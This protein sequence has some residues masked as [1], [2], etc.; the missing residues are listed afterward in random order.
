M[1]FRFS[2]LTIVT[3]AALTGC[4]LSGDPE[5]TRYQLQPDLTPAAVS[6]VRSSAILRIA[7][8]RAASSLDSNRIQIE[9]P[10][11]T[12]SFVQNA[13]WNEVPNKMLQPLLVQAL[14][15][16][17]IFSAVVDDQTTAE[18]AYELQT[19]LERFTLVGVN[20]AD[21]TASGGQPGVEAALRANLI[22]L[23]DNRLL[24]SKLVT[25]STPVDDV[26]MGVIIPAFE[27]ATGTILADTAADIAQAIR[28]TPPPT[29]A[30]SDA[31]NQ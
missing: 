14:S 9:Q 13:A 27:K 7:T 1:R 11:G 12:V 20:N 8:P 4:S 15:G 17:H 3:L 2:F 24:M 25:A 6:S 23:D 19:S 18:A 28:K 31:R 22:R 21:T 5:P 29:H 30:P 26:R 10:D 16:A